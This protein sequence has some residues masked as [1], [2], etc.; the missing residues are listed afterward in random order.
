ME[1]LLL[2]VLFALLYSLVPMVGYG[3]LMTRDEKKL[4]R[5]SP[6]AG[7]IAFV[8]GIF[9]IHVPLML[10]IAPRHKLVPFFHA[11][12]QVWPE[13]IVFT[14]LTLALSGRLRRTYTAQGC[15]DLWILPGLLTHIFLFLW[16][17]GRDPWIVLRLPRTVFRVLL[18]LWLA[19]FCAVMAWK[20]IGHLRFRRRILRLC[21]SLLGRR[22]F[23]GSAFR[24]RRGGRGCL[25]AAAGHQSQQHRQD[26]Q[27]YRPSHFH[28]NS[29][30]FIWIPTCILP[31]APS[32]HK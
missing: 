31:F 4:M 18:G 16:N 8:P 22:L 9:L 7:D 14:L 24:S 25:T 21:G 29:S 17:L 11:V 10:L 1:G 32:L 23:C 3:L 12:L 27:V 13:L 26:Q 2:R 6:L 30:F 20:I 15:A 19:G 28:N 5:Y